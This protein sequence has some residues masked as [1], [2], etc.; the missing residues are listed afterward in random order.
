VRRGP[1]IRSA[2]GS[3]KVVEQGP[4]ACLCSDVVGGVIKLISAALRMRISALLQVVS[5]CNFCLVGLSVFSFACSRDFQW[6]WRYVGRKG[7]GDGE[8]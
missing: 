5:F 4:A 2:T 7:N 1:K 6:R 3:D 8:V